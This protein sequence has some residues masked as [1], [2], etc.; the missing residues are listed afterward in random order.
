MT[1]PFVREW[2]RGQPVV[3]MAPLGLDS[4]AFA[5]LGELLAARG[6]H[7]LAV[8]LPGFGRTPAPAEPLTPAVLAAP[9]IALVRSL[10]VPPVVL[11]I[12]LGGRIALEVALA[13]PDAVRAV[14]P[15]APYLPWRRGRCLL[16]WARALDPAAAAW[17]PLERVWPGL[18]WLAYALERVPY[19]RDDAL[20]QAA[21][22]FVYYLSCP[23]TRVAFLSAAR[24]LALDPAE[25]PDALWARLAG[26]RMPAAFVWGERD[27]LVSLRFAKAVARACS[28]VEQILLPCVGHWLNGPHHRCLAETIADLVP[29][30]LLPPA[31]RRLRV[32]AGALSVRPCVAA[33]GV[34]AAAALAEAEHV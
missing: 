20:A 19:V 32:R 10:D 24:E 1:E 22:R 27:Q 4:S 14:V 30:L 21:A 7:T 12:S 5:A 16:A 26:L 17:L 25:G 18:R 15:I 33:A 34:P 9:V 11:G 28:P 6:M 3:A 31:V 13:A 2:G 23:A 8:D 29:A